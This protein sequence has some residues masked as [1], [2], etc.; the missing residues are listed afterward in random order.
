M[1]ELYHGECVALGI[2]PMCDEVIRPRVISVLKKCNL[3]RKLN[4]DWQKIAEAAFHD[5]K[6]DGKEVTVTTVSEIGSFNMKRVA[7]SDLIEMAKDCLEGF[8]E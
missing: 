6:A 7:S 3:L 1:S 4:Y 5:K 8:L 2:I